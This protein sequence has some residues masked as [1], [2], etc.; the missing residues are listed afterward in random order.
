MFLKHTGTCIFFIFSLLTLF[1][2]PKPVTLK[3][4]TCISIYNGWFCA[5]IIDSAK[6]NEKNTLFENE[7]FDIL[8]KGNKYY[9]LKT[10]EHQQMDSAGK[11][12]FHNHVFKK[13]PIDSFSCGIIAQSLYKQMEYEKTRPFIFEYKD[14]SNKTIRVD[15]TSSH[16][17]SIN[18]KVRFQERLCNKWFDIRSLQQSDTARGLDGRILNILK[19]VNYEYNQRLLSA[20]IFHYVESMIAKFE[21]ENRFILED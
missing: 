14:T 6:F 16:P 20:K 1:S 2:Q 15:G 18:L 13:I 17:C 10:V 19:N 3:Y 8:K 7:D 9:L 12:I 5:T 11:L 21:N 4:D